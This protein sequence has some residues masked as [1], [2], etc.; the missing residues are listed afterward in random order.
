MCEPFI[1]RSSGTFFVW[2]TNFVRY[3]QKSY[4]YDFRFFF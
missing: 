2:T 4:L 1:K 3:A